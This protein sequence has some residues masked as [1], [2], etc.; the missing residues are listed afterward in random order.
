VKEGAA[1]AAV[2]FG[3]LDAHDVSSKS[4]RG[5]F[6]GFCSLR[7]SAHE[8]TDFLVGELVD[9]VVNQPFFVRKRRKG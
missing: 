9:A 5:G 4:G 2:G 8:R 7:P 3:N 1:R 6:E